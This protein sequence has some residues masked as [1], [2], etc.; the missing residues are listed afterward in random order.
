MARV[1]F[2]VGRQTGTVFL[3]EVNTIPLHHHLDVSKMW[4]PRGCPYPAVFFLL[5]RLIAGGP[6]ERP[7]RKS[8][9]C[10]PASI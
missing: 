9:A 7:R 10:G 8:S 4:K 1:D 3:N 5:D 2:F 6:W